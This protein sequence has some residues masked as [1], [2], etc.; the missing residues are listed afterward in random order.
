MPVT[1]LST[2]AEIIAG[3]VGVAARRAREIVLIGVLLGS[4]LGALGA[5]NSGSEKD[6]TLPEG[7]LIGRMRREEEAKKKQAETNGRALLDPDAAQKELE[8]LNNTFSN[9]VQMAEQTK[10]AEEASGGVFR[11]VVI[12][13]VLLGAGIF[14]FRQF[15]SQFG[16]LH[17]APP[18][19]VYV[20]A[21][22]LAEEKSF[23][24]FD[25]AFRVGPI[26]NHQS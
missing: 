18:E 12:G 7:G 10:S 17:R 24:D 19:E 3:F 25:A 4:W 16:F 6:K 1:I 5:D 8:S 23:A 11:S 9:A 20:T 21:S 15:G 14:L 26:A 2:T 13:A 22:N